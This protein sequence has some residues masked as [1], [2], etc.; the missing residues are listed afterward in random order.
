MSES[1][2]VSAEL[3]EQTWIVRLTHPELDSVA[4]E[5]LSQELGDLAEKVVAGPVVLDLSSV[6][7]LQSTALGALITF[8]NRL[9]GLG[10]QVVLAGLA[11][12]IRRAIT[13]TRL[14][15]LFGVYDDVDQALKALQAD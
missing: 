14:D 12:R 3:H 8:R 11:P 6:S 15:V 5:Q 2:M 13:V 7:F 4:S 1:S 9:K 10:G